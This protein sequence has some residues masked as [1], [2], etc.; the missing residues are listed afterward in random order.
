MIVKIPTAII[1]ATIV[2]MIFS[3]ILKP[4]FAPSI[5]ASYTGTFLENAKPYNPHDKQGNDHV[6]YDHKYIHSFT[7][8]QVLFLSLYEG[9][10]KTISKKSILE[11]RMNR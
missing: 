2:G 7:F 5:K 4:L 9:T 8:C 6:G 10:L 3:T 11:S 1:S